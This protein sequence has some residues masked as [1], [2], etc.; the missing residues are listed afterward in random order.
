MYKHQYSIYYE[1]FATYASLD[2][3]NISVKASRKLHLTVTSLPSYVIRHSSVSLHT[4]AHHTVTH[5]A[6]DTVTHTVT[7]TVTHTVTYL[8]THTVHSDY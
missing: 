8:V 2:I 5:T 6:T 7:D 1:M 3:A 4:F